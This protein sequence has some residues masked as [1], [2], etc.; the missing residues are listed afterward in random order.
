MT[1]AGASSGSPNPARPRRRRLVLILLAALAALPVLLVVAYVVWRPTPP[2][3]GP[4]IGLSM[5]S[6][7]VVQRPLYEDALARAGGRPVLITPTDDDARLEAML[8]GID[9]LLLTG[10]DDVDPTQYN[11]NPQPA[12]SADSRRDAFEIRLIRGALDRNLPILGICRGIQ[13]LNVAHGGTI[14]DLRADKALSD[15]HGIGVDSFS[16]HDVTIVPGTHLADAVGAGVHRVN[17]FHGQA[18]DQ[19]GSGLRASATADDGVI[20]GIER[21]DRAFVIGIQWHPEITS[22]TDKS[23]L[24]LYQALVRQ[25]DAHRAT[26][27]VRTVSAGPAARE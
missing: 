27:R 8:D 10:G 5:A 23:A 2:E 3:G 26:R 17:S 16:A 11:G 14:R 12:T 22:L 4:K 18:V 25:A 19:V 20:E 9:G 7:F 24:A 6:S 13:I 15:H 1:E 21:P